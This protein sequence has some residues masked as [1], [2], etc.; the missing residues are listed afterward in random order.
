MTVPD[1]RRHNLPVPLTNFIGRDR[2][3]AELLRLVA[4]TRLLTLTGAGGCGKTRLALELAANVLDRFPD[5]VWMVD[6]AAICNSSLVTQTVASVLD[7]REGPNRPIREALSDY[8][9]N[10]QILLVLDNCEHLIAACAELAEALLR[11]APA[12][13]HPGDEPRGARHHRR[14][15][16]AGPFLVCSGTASGSFRRDSA[17]S[18]T[19]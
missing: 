1:A 14:N 5:G 18:T 8:V 3:M 9:R 6:L 17:P 7:V 16:V 19:R 10:R 2:E 11:T 12:I 15:P 4:S 13:A